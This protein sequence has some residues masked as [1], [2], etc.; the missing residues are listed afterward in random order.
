MFIKNISTTYM[1]F[2]RQISQ[3]YLRMLAVTERYNQLNGSLR[4]G[5]FIL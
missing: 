1:Y 2:Q 4:Q 5:A 3:I